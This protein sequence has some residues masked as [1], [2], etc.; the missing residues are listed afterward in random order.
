M[1]RT[2][3]I[4]IFILVALVIGMASA[5]DIPGVIRYQ[6]VIDGVAAGS[7]MD[8]EFRLYDN[9]FDQS[10]QLVWGELHSVVTGSDGA[11]TVL[12]GA[13]T[14]LGE[15]A[16]VS[17]IKYAFGD[18]V[19]YLE[20]KILLD[21]PLSETVRISSIPYALNSER[22]NIASTIEGINLTVDSDT[23]FVGIG[24]QTP[25]AKLDVDGNVT[26]AGSVIAQNFVGDGSN[27]TG[28]TEK[29]D[30]PTTLVSCPRAASGEN[31]TC[32]CPSGYMMYGIRYYDIAYDGEQA[33]NVNG[34]YCIKIIGN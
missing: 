34:I 16:P 32:S 17:D 13:G 8:I 23:G 10:G 20:V 12:L 5:G 31:K 27:L 18:S 11:Y 2:I 29:W 6:G 9:S 14:D 3:S 24:T 25:Q 4:V 1:K 28:T 21:P 7:T 33:E 22:S 15:S 19:R 26:V 30:T